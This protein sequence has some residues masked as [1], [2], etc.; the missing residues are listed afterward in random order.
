MYINKDLITNDV[1][2]KMPSGKF[3]ELCN[4]LKVESEEGDIKV[5]VSV[6]IRTDSTNEV[7]V[8]DKSILFSQEVNNKNLKGYFALANACGQVLQ[9]NTNTNL[10]EIVKKTVLLPCGAFM[11]K[12][13]LHFYFN[14]I[15]KP[16]IKS[17]FI[18]SF[19]NIENIKLIDLPKK[20]IIILPT[21]VITSN[22][23]E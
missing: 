8:K 2:F 3:N 12:N 10:Q 13:E 4:N 7:L 9:E 16:E 11:Y 5:N 22:K 19:E 21:M 15:I 18:S 20:D 23:E 17:S 1:M 6:L 14:L